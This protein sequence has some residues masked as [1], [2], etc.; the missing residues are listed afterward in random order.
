MFEPAIVMTSIGVAAAGVLAVAARAF[1]VDID[2]RIA[3]VSYNFV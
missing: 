2:P 1:H 3:E